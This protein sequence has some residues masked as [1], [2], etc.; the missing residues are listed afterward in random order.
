MPGSGNGMTATA[1]RGGRRR[2]GEK[3]TRKTARKRKNPGRRKEHRSTRRLCC[4][5]LSRRSGPIDRRDLL[6]F[7]SHSWAIIRHSRL[8]K[9]SIRTYIRQFNKIRNETHHNHIQVIQ[10]AM[11]YANLKS[12]AFFSHENEQKRVRR[13][14]VYLPGPEN[15]QIFVQVS[16]L[17]R[18]IRSI[19]RQGS[20][21]VYIH[22]ANYF[23]SMQ[24]CK[25]F[26]ILKVL[27]DIHSAVPYHNFK[28]AYE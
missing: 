25:G 18:F 22:L 28:C 6:Q 2:A 23:H 20:L 13:R 24:D 15:P 19:E 3:D 27:R 21:Q 7:I 16:D 8:S 14:G 10:G 4:P 17:S 9:K 26:S 11:S 1:S 5:D 12:T